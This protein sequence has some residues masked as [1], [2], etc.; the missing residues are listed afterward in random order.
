MSLVKHGPGEGPTREATLYESIKRPFD[1]LNW[2]PE[3]RQ[4]PDGT[5]DPTTA[6]CVSVKRRLMPM[7]VFAL[8]KLV[9]I[10][11]LFSTRS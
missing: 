11:G 7:L 3:K 10:T 8:G 6:Y 4:G 5:G 1:P 2:L 9:L